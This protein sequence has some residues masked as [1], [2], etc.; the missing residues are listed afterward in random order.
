MHVAKA[1]RLSH[2]V[3]L[4]LA[5]QNVAEGGEGVV[6]R[7]VVNVDVEVLNENISKALM[8]VPLSTCLQIARSARNEPICGW[9][10]RG[11]TT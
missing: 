7:L 1:T 3:S 2:L 9:T 5:R 10:G 8:V 6:Q 11:V 4:N